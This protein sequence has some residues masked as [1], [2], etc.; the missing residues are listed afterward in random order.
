MLL[1]YAFSFVHR[2]FRI[3]HQIY[4]STICKTNCQDPI[5]CTLPE[6][7]TSR[8]DPGTFSTPN[9]YLKEVRRE[10]FFFCTN[11][12]PVFAPKTSCGYFLLN[13]HQ[14]HQQA[15]RYKSFTSVHKNMLGLS[16][17]SSHTATGT[18]DSILHFLLC[19]RAS[20]S[21][22]SSW[23]LKNLPPRDLA[24][25]ESEIGH[26]TRYLQHCRNKDNTILY[27]N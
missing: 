12:F 5:T 20:V 15:F 23:Q 27:Y 18:T 24:P 13:S 3:M 8:H 7:K 4:T 19:S 21:E 9:C 6:N 2:S 14:L 25:Q 11:Q 17:M 26:T 1:I 22:S 10:N 16:I